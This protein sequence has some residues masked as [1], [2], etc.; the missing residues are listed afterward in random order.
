MLW[1]GQAAEDAF[2]QGKFKLGETKWSAE[3]KAGQVAYYQEGRP[4]SSPPLPAVEFKDR[5]YL[6]LHELLQKETKNQSF[7]EVILEESAGGYQLAE[8]AQKLDF[9]AKPAQRNSRTEVAE[10]KIAELQRISRKQEE[11]KREESSLAEL[12]KQ[13]AEIKEAQQELEL[14]KE[15]INLVKL[16]R[17]LIQA[18][19]R[20]NRFPEQM[21]RLTGTEEERLAELQKKINQEKER[22]KEAQ[23]ELDKAEA[24]LTEVELPSVG[25]EDRLLNILKEKRDRLQT[26]REAISSLKEKLAANK[27]KEEEER[28]NFSDFLVVEDLAQLPRV[29]YNQ[30]RELARRAERVHNKLHSFNL[31][32]DLLKVEA[33]LPAD[34]RTVEQGIQ[35]LEDWLQE[36]PM[37][38][39]QKQ[40]LQVISRAATLIV[41]LMAVIMGWLINPWFLLFLLFGAGFGAYGLLKGSLSI[42]SRGTFQSKFRQ[43]EIKQPQRWKTKQ[44]RARL[45]E[46]RELVAEINLFARCDQYWASREAEYQNLVAEQKEL[47]RQRQQLIERFGVAPNTGDEQTL[48]YLTNRLSR[49]QDAYS[50]VVALSR[51]L[52][53]REREYK[54]LLAQL[55]DLLVDYGYKETTDFSELRSNINQLEERN[56]KFQ[57]AR[58][59]Q[60]QAQQSLAETEKRLAELEA[61]KEELFTRLN[62][63]VDDQLGLKK[64]CQQYDD[65]QQAQQQLAEQELLYQSK[66]QELKKYSNFNQ[67]LLQEDLAK[68]KE[69]KRELAAQ[70]AAYEEVQRSINEIETKLELAK[71]ENNAE[72]A[73]LEQ[74]RALAELEEELQEDYAQLTGQMLFEHLQQ[75]NRPAKKSKVF[76]QAQQLFTSITLGSYELRFAKGDQPSFKAF[77]TVADQEKSLAQLSS[78]IRVQLLLAVRMAFII[79]QEQGLVLP[80]YLDEALANADQQRAKSVI[81]AVME[82][83]GEGRQ[84]FYFTAREDEVVQWTSLLANQS[85]LECNVIELSEKREIKQFD[86]TEKNLQSTELVLEVEE[87][88]AAPESHWEYKELLSVTAFNPRQGASAAH[89]WYLV[90]D[91]ELLEQLLKLGIDSWGQLKAL[92]KTENWDFISSEQEELLAEVKEL[93]LLLEEFVDSW[94]LGRGKLVDRSTLWDSGAVSEN[95]IEEVSQLAVEV[96]RDAE[97]II[98]KMRQGAVTNFRNQKLA[99]LEEYFKEEG[100][101]VDTDKLPGKQIRARLLAKASGETGA[102]R[103]E[104]VDSLLKRLDFA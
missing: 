20:C 100:Y 62:L 101:I 25:V 41:S 6:S 88:P 60:E 79:Q 30:L 36:P 11:L 98:K 103:A 29:G 99:E 76:Q 48:Y 15:V 31:L 21:Q 95:F 23:Q 37:K 92:L 64:L 94:H 53:G 86:L 14:I 34:K 54:R 2:L 59:D 32:K 63:K 26:K 39:Q 45:T 66:K 81:E 97:A 8:A 9:K 96:G 43:L 83:L 85:N 47:A 72:K 27:A 87:I 82:L 1:P 78:G 50:E 71:Q 10:A 3:I 73:L 65:Y 44:V 74:E 69:R 4:H 24:V 75:A 13:L 49:W 46:L 35:Y 91:T 70:A 90:E 52:E 12:K 84:C 19:Q 56:N 22:S 42:D 93:G 102:E 67:S 17:D 16:K 38:H 7:A 61:E 28:K 51:R 57:R 40:E 33:E 77:D 55:N 68:L 5:Y 89:L 18:R 58:R 80:L 104:K